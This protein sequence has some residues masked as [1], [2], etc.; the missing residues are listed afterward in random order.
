MNIQ[1]EL[2]LREAV[3]TEFQLD[4]DEPDA[5]LRALNNAYLVIEDSCN[6][7]DAVANCVLHEILRAR[8][9]ARP[10]QQG[11]DEP[12]FWSRPGGWLAYDSETVA[13]WAR[14]EDEC[15]RKV[16]KEFTV[17][18]YTRAA[19][20]ASEPAPEE[21]NYGE[22]LCELNENEMLGYAQDSMEPGLLERWQAACEHYIE[23]TAHSTTGKVTP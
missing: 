20:P 19:E 5:V 11:A 3:P 1:P 17:P 18:F 9:L 4:T 2:S 22:L 12:A 16:A 15:T 23:S 13:R 7:K 8:S 10:P 14:D 6:E 21:P